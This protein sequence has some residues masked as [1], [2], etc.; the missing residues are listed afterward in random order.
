MEAGKI[1]IILNGVTFE[2]TK[3]LRELIHTLLSNGSLSI[4][5]GR[6]II[7]FDSNANIMKIDHEFIK[8]SKKHNQ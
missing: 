2:E 7:H 8:W 1:E 6:A 3:R 4:K 5:N